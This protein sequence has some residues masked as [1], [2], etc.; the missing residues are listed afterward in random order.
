M[1]NSKSKGN[2][3]ERVVSKRLSLW[4]S[5]YEHDDLFWR[6]QGSGSRWTVR[7]KAGI[8]T[9]GQ[10]SDIASTNSAS[11]LFTDNFSI[12]CKSYKDIQLWSLIERKGQ[13]VD[14]WNTLMTE[15]CQQDKYPLLVCKQNYKEV[16]LFG[17]FYLRNILNKCSVSMRGCFNINTSILYMYNFEEFLDCDIH[18]FRYYLEHGVQ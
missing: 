18:K 4:W 3:F 10:S 2:S 13:I 7:N 12:E 11:E 9:I 5:D 1:V 8:D 16:L 14:W 17:N 6:T 15:C